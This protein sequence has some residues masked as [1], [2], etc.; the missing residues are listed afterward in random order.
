MCN[1]ESV[2][3]CPVRWGSCVDKSKE[4]FR[5]SAI[6]GTEPASA[7]GSQFKRFQYASS[8]WPAFHG[9]AMQMPN[10]HFQLS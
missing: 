9:R 1:L 10:G 7:W 4:A 3:S 5:S 2:Q 6:D 8:M